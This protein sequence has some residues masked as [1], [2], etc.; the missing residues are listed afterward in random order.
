M[1]QAPSQCHLG[2]SLLM[3]FGDRQ[4][5]LVLEEF[6]IAASQ[7]RVSLNRYFMLPAKIDSLAFP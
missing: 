7:R 6:G 5:S 1:L 2:Y 3:L 4:D